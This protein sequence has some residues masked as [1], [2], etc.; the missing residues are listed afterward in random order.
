MKKIGI[1]GSGAVAKTLGNGFIKHGYDVMLGTR[2][3]EKLN[4][5]KK[6][7]GGKTG[8]FSDAAA[9]G[10]ILVLAAKGTAAMEVLKLAGNVNLK[11]KTIIDTTNPIAATPP[12]NAVLH[13]FTTLEESLME[14]LQKEFTEANFVKAFNSVGNGV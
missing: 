14:R 6:Q 2:D 5:W 8:S 11:G 9:H 12:T 3:L 7:G 4:D 1:L 10:E 13:Y